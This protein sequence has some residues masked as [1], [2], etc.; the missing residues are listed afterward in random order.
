MVAVRPLLR[1]QTVSKWL[2]I[3]NTVQRSCRTLQLLQN[4]CP[5]VAFIFKNISVRRWNEQTTIK[6]CNRRTACLCPS[7]GTCAK[8]GCNGTFLSR[9]S[10]YYAV[11]THGNVYV[12]ISV[13]KHHSQSRLLITAMDCW[14]SWCSCGAFY[15]CSRTKICT[16]PPVCTSSARGTVV[17]HCTCN[18]C[19]TC[20]LNFQFTHRCTMYMQCTNSTYYPC[21]HRCTLYVLPTL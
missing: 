20:N 12:A 5:M 9:K 3:H 14:Q 10:P 7:V 4:K 19:C 2:Q 21:T 6:P 13:R 15:T 18:V 16:K 17:T 11:I 1:F 8:S